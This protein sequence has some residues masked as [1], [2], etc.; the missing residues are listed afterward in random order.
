MYEFFIKSNNSQ[1]L[2]LVEFP[3]NF[4]PVLL[5]HKSS[6]K[7]MEGDSGGVNKRYIVY[8]MNEDGH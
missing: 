6:K 3:A 4:S 1:G 7:G 8:K 5:Y 2:L